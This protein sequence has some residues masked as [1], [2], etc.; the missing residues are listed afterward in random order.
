VGVTAL[1][2]RGSINSGR[3]ESSDLGV[4]LRLVGAFRVMMILGISS[5]KTDTEGVPWEEAVDLRLLLRLFVLFGIVS[6]RQ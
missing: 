1:G 4:V 2:E 5:V 6:D 3:S